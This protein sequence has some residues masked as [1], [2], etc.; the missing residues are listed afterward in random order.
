MVVKVLSVRINGFSL[1]EYQCPLRDYPTTCCK[2]LISDR[3]SHERK[4]T[5]HMLTKMFVLHHNPTNN[6]SSYFE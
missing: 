5:N 2:H 6:Y 1:K 3:L 4:T